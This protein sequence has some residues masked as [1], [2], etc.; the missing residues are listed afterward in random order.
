MGEGIVVIVI[1]FV[2]RESG[3]HSFALCVSLHL[4]FKF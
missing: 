1:I 3:S 2:F 4:G